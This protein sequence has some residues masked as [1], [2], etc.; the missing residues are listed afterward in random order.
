M[1]DEIRV[2]YCA[3]SAYTNPCPSLSFAVRNPKFASSLDILGQG[4]SHCATRA[5]HSLPFVIPHSIPYSSLEVPAQSAVPQRDTSHRHRSL[6]YST[7]IHRH[8]KHKLRKVLPSTV[9]SPWHLEVLAHRLDRTATRKGHSLWNLFL[10]VYLSRHT[11]IP[12]RPTKDPPPLLAFL[13]SK[14]A[15]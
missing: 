6:F 9:N 7:R 2:T 11:Q 10:G 5:H 3:A 15:R 1:S 14:R 13:G 8:S 4:S 12:V